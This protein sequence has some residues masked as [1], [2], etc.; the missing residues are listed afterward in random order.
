[1]FKKLT[2]E[3]CARY[4]QLKGLAQR[5]I[6]SAAREHWQ[7]YCSTLNKNSKLSGVWNMTKRMNGIQHNSSVLPSLV[8]NGS[9]I[10]NTMEKANILAQAFAEVSSDNNYSSH[11]LTRRKEFEENEV[12]EIKDGATCGQSANKNNG[13]LNDLFSIHELRRAVRECKTGSSPGEDEITYEMLQKLPKT[14]N[15]ALLDL[16]NRIWSSGAYPKAWQHSIVVP[17]LK[18]GKD[19]HF[20]KSYRPISLT[21]TV[22]KVRE[23]L[24]SN[25][26][27][28]HVE[29]NNLLTNVQTGFRKG[30]GAIDQII[31]LQDTIN[32]YNHNRG[33]TL[34]V[35]VDFQTAFDM[36]WRNGLLYKLKKLDIQGNVLEY[37]QHFL[38]NRSIQVRIGGEFS[39]TYS[40]QNGTPQGSVLSPLLF[41]LMINDL[42]DKLTKIETSIFAD[43]T[44]LFKSGQNLD[45]VTRNVQKNLNSLAS[46]CDLWGFKINLDKT[47]AVLFTHRRGGCYLEINDERIKM[48]N[49]AKFLGLIF[50]AKLTWAEHIN[51]LTNRCK[52]RLNLMRAVAGTTWGASKKSLLTIYRTLIRSVLDYGSIAYNSASDSNKQKLNSIQTQA[53]QIACGAMRGTAAAALQI[54][55]GELPLELRRHQQEL[56]YALKIKSAINHPA[57]SIIERHRTLLSRRYNENTLPFY[58]KVSEF[59]NHI[60]DVKIEGPIPAPVAP[61]KL[62]PPEVDMSLKKLGNKTDHHSE[63]KSAAME[64]IENMNNNLKLYTDGSKTADGNTAAAYCVPEL[65]VSSGIKLSK[66]LTIYTAELTAIKLCLNWLV[67]KESK[68]ELDRPVV[69][70]SDSHSAL[71]SIESSKSTSR[72]NLLNEVLCLVG[73]LSQN[74]KF[75]WIPSH[76]G[77]KGNEMADRAAVA[78]T[79]STS[80]ELDIK[81]E[82]KESYSLARKYIENRWQN[83]WDKTKVASF[84]K[85]LEP[86]VSNSVK[87]VDASRYREVTITRLRLGKCRLNAYLHDMKLHD[88]GLC[89][90]CDEKETIEHFLLNC[91]KNNM[92]THVKL[93]CRNLK[94][95]CDLKTILNNKRVTDAIIKNL[96][97]KI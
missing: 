41:L 47:V 51:Y 74:L 50:D 95:A 84:Y 20:A 55:T 4:R 44:C 48:E 32:K 97:R 68:G 36:L 58:H 65:N 27:S 87:F 13:F 31:R 61:W 82:L 24:V 77:I 63:M 40:V 85:K 89:D 29:K 3:N 45:T 22:G 30:R 42:P 70:F 16:F 39:R 81:L 8:H 64:M 72:P 38:S 69:I 67:D 71:A 28:Y 60:S 96:N 92:A 56:Q 6:K 1:M 17:I 19:P 91:T 90:L 33:Y 14:S 75:V 54:E 7:S 83:M 26:L 93:L 86:F 94:I 66:N 79:K 5:E 9:S 52:K 23:K 2:D 18:Q 88:S 15:K 73:K 78:A 53:L 46:W 43:D 62:K 59:V 25:R 12:L 10:E 11:F 49:H 34:A 37:I 35:F 80:T 21:S 57:K 76:V